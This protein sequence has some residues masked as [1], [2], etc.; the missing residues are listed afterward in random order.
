VIQ[1]Q[2]EVILVNRNHDADEVVK[3]VQQKNIGAHNNISN[4][5]EPIMAQN[6][7]YIGLHS[8]FG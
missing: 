6:G 4:L 2:P 5:V 7:L 8:Q 3:N 1:V